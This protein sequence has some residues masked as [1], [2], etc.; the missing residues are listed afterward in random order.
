MNSS[1]DVKKL[2]DYSK[3]GIL[4]KEIIRK[5]NLDVTLFCMAK[6]TSISEHTS[7]K[8]GFVYVLEGK[9][10]FRLEGKD[11][12]MKEGVLINLEKNA[13]HS[14]KAENDT[15]FILSLWKNKE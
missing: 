1:T 4:S 15:S 7:T 5:E 11:I 14:L 9:G 13:K 10:V 3:G 6:G 12:I 2:I 8:E